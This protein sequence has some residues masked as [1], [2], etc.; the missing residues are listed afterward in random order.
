MDNI[1]VDNDTTYST[2]IIQNINNYNLTFEN[3]NLIIKRIEPIQNQYITYEEL[4]KKNLRNSKIISIHIDN[5]L[6]PN[7]FKYKR[8]IKHIYQHL[9]KQ[10]II[11]NTLINVSINE[12]N[13]RGYV[14]DSDIGLS[15]QGTD[16]KTSLKEIINQITK[17]NQQIEIKIKL[18]CGEEIRFIQ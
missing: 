17:N 10:T 5:Q 15:I 3:N 2:I 4:F 8:L 11:N 9:D 18:K 14:Y 12:I 1:I 13:E 7:I 6:I 16:A